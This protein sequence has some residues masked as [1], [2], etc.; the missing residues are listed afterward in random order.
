MVEQEANWEMP[1]HFWQ[2]NGAK[3]LPKPV[4]EYMRQEFMLR[5][6]Y[7]TELRCFEYDGV[8]HEKPVRCIRIFSPHLAQEQHISIRTNEDLDQHPEVLLYE[9]YI[10]AQGNAYINDQRTMSYPEKMSSQR[11]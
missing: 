11:L 4:Q 8:I 5:R 1:F 2:R 10:D 7:L 3:R 6:E 9:G